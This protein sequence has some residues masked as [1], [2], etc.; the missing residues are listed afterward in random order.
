MI[1]MAFAI[2][3]LFG[4]LCTFAGVVLGYRKFRSTR[5]LCT[6]EQ[7]EEAMKRRIDYLKRVSRQYGV[8]TN[9][10]DVDWHVVAANLASDLIQITQ[11]GR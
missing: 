5:I 7:I 10:D 6:S 1:G 3:T 4:S 9:L 8:E 11:K 2:G